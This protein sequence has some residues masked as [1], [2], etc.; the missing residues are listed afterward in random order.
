MEQTIDSWNHMC[1]SQRFTLT[2]KAKPFMTA[3][4][5][6]LG[7]QNT[8]QRTDQWLPRLLGDEKCIYTCDVES[9]SRSKVIFFFFS[10]E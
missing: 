4:H 7:K 9:N 10:G 8:G 3:R 2:Q 5:A 6:V 1:E